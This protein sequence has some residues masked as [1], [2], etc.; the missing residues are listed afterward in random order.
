MLPR[1]EFI[2]AM[3]K[4]TLQQAQDASNVSHELTMLLGIASSQNQDIREVKNS[5]RAIDT[6]L[7]SFDVRFDSLETKLNEHATLL[8]QILAR[9]PEK[10]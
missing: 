3:N 10:P 5:L 1:I 2:N 9:L 6:R 4:F 7:G 8:T